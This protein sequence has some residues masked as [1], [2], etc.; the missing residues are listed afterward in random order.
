MPMPRDEHEAFLNEL[1]L[2]D[3]EQ[4]RRTEILQALRV[5]YGTVLTDFDGLTTSNDKLKADNADLVISNSK[6]FRQIGIDSGDN[7]QKE[8]EKEKSFSESVTLESIEQSN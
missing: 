3:T 6:L 8:K 4:S 2:P 5:D 1:L 7:K